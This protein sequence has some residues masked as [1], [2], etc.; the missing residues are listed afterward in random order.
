MPKTILVC[1]DDVDILDVTGIF[2]QSQAYNVVKLQSCHRFFDCLS[3]ANPD[4]VL[5]DIWMPEITGDAIARLI[6]SND[7]TKH[8]PVLLFSAN[9]DVDK[10]A[11][12]V[13]ADGYLR[14]PF[15]LAELKANIDMHLNKS[16]PKE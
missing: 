11:Q 15:D 7:Q 1:D 16:N 14:K 9:T 5:L 4:L 6:K 13:G 2:L 10:V 8:L 12:E 3:K